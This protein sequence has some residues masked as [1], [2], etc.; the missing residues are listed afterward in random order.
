MLTAAQIIRQYKENEDDEESSSKHGLD[1]WM[2]HNYILV[3]NPDKRRVMSSTPLGL[4]NAMA[5]WVGG[6]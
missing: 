4:K 1:A 6:R 3:V 5:R 2:K